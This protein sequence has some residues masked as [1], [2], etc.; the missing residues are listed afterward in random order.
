MLK[1]YLISSLDDFFHIFQNS[2]N[3]VFLLVG[4]DSDF[5]HSRLTEYKGEVYGAIFPQVIY[6]NK[7]FTDA[8]I[9]IELSESTNV[10]LTAFNSFSSSDIELDG[11]DILVFVDGLSS[12]VT[13]FLEELY[14]STEIKNNILGGG[15]GK[16][17][18][19]QEPVLFSKEY[20]IQDGALIITDSWHFS[21]AVSNSWEK[22]SGPHLVTEADKLELYTLDF[23]DAFEVYKEVVEKDSGKSFSNVDFFELSKFYPLG[24]SRVNGELVVRDPIYRKDGTLV[25]VGDID[26][27]SII[28]ILKGEKEK[29]L[30]AAKSAAVNAISNQDNFQNV[31]MADCISRVL[32]LESD[33]E[34]ELEFVVQSIDNDE[35]T[36]LGVLSLGEIAN[37]NEGYIE[38]YNKTCVI[39]AF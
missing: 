22:I 3:K 1:N 28:Y 18:L 8:I 27:S 9:A 19:K 38:F 4:E 35:V 14:E 25:L 36:L 34:R 37:V 26:K 7:H 32:V 12:G 6:G 39:G 30:N 2:S 16:L 17:T 21:V 10:V 13:N 29:L 33:Y 31:F 24:L 5:E 20:L 15:A 23:R 11:S